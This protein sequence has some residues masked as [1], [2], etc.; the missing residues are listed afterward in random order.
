MYSWHF[1]QFPGY[2][3]AH[4]KYSIQLEGS[5]EHW[6]LNLI[7]EEHLTKFS[8]PDPTP[9]FSG[10]LMQRWDHPSY[11]DNSSDVAPFRRFSDTKT[12]CPSKN[13]HRHRC[14]C[15]PQQVK[16]L[17][18]FVKCFPVW[19]KSLYSRDLISYH[20]RILHLETTSRIPYQR[21]SPWGPW[22][23]EPSD[24]LVEHI[25]TWQCFCFCK[26]ADP[27][28]ACLPRRLSFT[29]SLSSHQYQMT[30]PDTRSWVVGI[31]SFSQSPTCSKHYK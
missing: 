21:E 22:Q 15:D 23:E 28:P 24:K 16:L 27:P 12:F 13:T 10:S 20:E 31:G 11:Y 19:P 4:S 29:E 17:A 8:P 26:P 7:P 2:C 5:S 14:G 1:P 9:P 25:G 6:T 3:I 18:A 30:I